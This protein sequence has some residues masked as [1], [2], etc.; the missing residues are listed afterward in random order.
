[1]GDKSIK[2][3]EVKKK[4]KVIATATSTTVE[5]KS[6]VTQPE[7]ITKAKKEK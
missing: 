4:K 7:V 2:N 1:M 3:K 6:V 5:I